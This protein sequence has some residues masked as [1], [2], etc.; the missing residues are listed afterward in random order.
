MT[1]KL[2]NL[3]NK[4]CPNGV[5]YYSLGE[6]A[7]CTKGA[8]LNKEQLLDEGYPVINGGINPS[9]FWNTY[10]FP[11]NK[12]TISQGGASAGYVNWQ[13]NKFW[14]GAHCYVIVEEKEIVNYKFLFYKFT[15]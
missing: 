9:G 11:E 4:L 12:I 2:Q 3:I 8:Q 13:L 10:N 15:H 1:G 5:P 14:A 6:L 7:K